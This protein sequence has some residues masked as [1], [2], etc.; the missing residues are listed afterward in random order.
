MANPV[1]IVF[2]A[3]TF[4][5]LGTNS[6]AVTASGPVDAVGQRPWRLSGR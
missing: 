5:Y 3:D 1:V 6:T 2:A 4:R